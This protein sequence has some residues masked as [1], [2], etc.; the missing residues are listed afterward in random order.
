MNRCRALQGLKAGL[1]LA[2]LAI[3]WLPANAADINL[4][5]IYKRQVFVQTNSGVPSPRCCSFMFDAIVELTESNSITAAALAAPG[6]TQTA[7]P[8]SEEQEFLPHR[9]MSWTCGSFPNQEALDSAWANGEYTFFIFG[10]RDKLMTPGL[11]LSGDAYPTNAPHVQ[12]FVE[13]QSVDAAQN[14]AVRWDPLPEGTTNDVVF[15][16]VRSVAGNTTVFNTPFLKGEGTL[17][18]TAS[19][20]TIPAGTLA[21]GCEYDVYV[22]FDKVSQR[23]V[24]AAGV[25]G[26]ASYAV[27]TH[28]SL[29]TS[30]APAG[31]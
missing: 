12:N 27:G 14:F 17:D 2:F 8:V 7:L 21:P 13:A 20:V 3:A 15:V 5:A 19:A 4:Y 22:R 24:E 26:Q 25:V 9:W 11:K 29:K 18:G 23:N 10:T 30:P 6:G 31:S 28:F 1:V 16:S